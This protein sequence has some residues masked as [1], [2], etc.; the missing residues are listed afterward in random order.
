MADRSWPLYTH[1]SRGRASRRRVSALRGLPR[2]FL[3]D[4]A[5][6]QELLGESSRG[7]R[8]DEIATRDFGLPRSQEIEGHDAVG[9]GIAD[10][11]QGGGVLRIARFLNLD[12][13][14]RQ[15]EAEHDL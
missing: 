13:A 3:G 2:R 8:R 6:G 11:E 12:E 5:A 10:G 9:R 1:R 4:L 15:A 14:V 7:G